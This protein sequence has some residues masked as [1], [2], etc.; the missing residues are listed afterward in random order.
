MTTTSDRSAPGFARGQALRLQPHTDHCSDVAELSLYARRL[1]LSA[2]APLLAADLFSGA[3]GM[4]L[5]LEQAGMRVILGADHDPDALETHAHHFGGMA[6]DWDLGDADRV[7]ELGKTLR[8]VGIDVIAGGPPCQPFSKAGRSG[9]RYLVQHGVREPHDRRRDLWQ[10]YLEIV[11]LAKPRAVI[12]ENVPDMALDREMF[13]LRSIVK[14]LEDWGY[15]VQE[16]VIDTYRYGVPQFRQR[17]ILV[18][19]R[20][21]LDFE[22]PAESTKK[23]TLGNAIQDL[24]AVDPKGGWQS[25]SAQRGWATYARRPGNDFQREM[26]ANVSSAHPDRVYDHVTRRVRDDDQLA[27]E[28]LDVKTKYS[29]LPEHLKRYRDDIFDDKYK[30][31]DANDL[32]RTITA[33]IAKDGYW[34]IHPEQNRT[35][36]IREAARVQ[37]FPDHFRFAGAPTSAFRQIGNAVPPRLG[38]A[39]GE[40]VAEV[41]TAGAPRL[42]TPTATTRAALA[43]WGRTS[44]DVSPWLLTGSRW[45]VAIGDALLGGETDMVT[46]ALWPIVSGW[47]SPTDLLSDQDTLLEVATWLGKEG[48]A[49]D[50]IAFASLIVDEHASL[51]DDRMA[52]WVSRGLLSRPLAE[53]AMLAD[54]K[55]EEPVIAN[56]AAL[57]VAGRFFQGSER[58]LSNRNSD[59][60]IAVGRLIGFDE[61]SRDAQIALV[62]LGQRVCSPKAPACG[63][64]PLSTWCVSANR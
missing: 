5:G 38:R 27:F 40:A 14:R 28:H 26:R 50:L 31:L 52:E 24:P 21:G 62:E 15:S 55:G 48:T 6:V 41:L 44:S 19:L 43:R 2:D 34:Y 53:L 12:M 39:I 13:I 16:R 47:S 33:H 37:T 25:D 56:T 54:P 30:R 17:L 51:D 18:A 32:C 42:A 7:E 45:L 29:D 57:R 22:W 20:G 49:T 11:R 59:G 8:A 61:E 10:S 63:R 58:W 64:C 46:R 36:T 23:V 3:G 60:R 4:S 9:M 1:R 35:L